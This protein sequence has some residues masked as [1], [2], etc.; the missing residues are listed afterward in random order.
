MNKTKIVP[1]CLFILCFFILALTLVRIR[2]IH[3]M[4]QKIVLAHETNKALYHLMFDLSQVREASIQDVPADGAWHDHI[5]FMRAPQGEQ[6]YVVQGRELLLVDNG[7]P[8]S[9]A[10]NIVGLRIRRHMDSPGIL[11]VQIRAQKD[12]T[13]LSNFRIRLR[14]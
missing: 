2:E 3:R 1:V 11:E 14:H 6:E 9:I 10:E 4:D 8:S 7:K 12:V 13:L 5:T